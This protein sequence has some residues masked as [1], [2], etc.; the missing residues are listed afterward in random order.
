MYNS[1]LPTPTGSEISQGFRGEAPTI[2]AE[3]NRF[4][5]QGIDQ[6][7]IGEFDVCGIG[8]G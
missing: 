4:E 2:L 7:H 3:Q 6:R 8:N 5:P 1:D